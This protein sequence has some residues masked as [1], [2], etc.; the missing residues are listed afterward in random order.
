MEVDGSGVL[1]LFFFSVSSMFCSCHPDPFD[2]AEGTPPKTKKPGKW[3]ALEDHLRRHDF[4]MHAAEHPLQEPDFPE[5][6]PR[7]ATGLPW[8]FRVIDLLAHSV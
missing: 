3:E 1:T 2:L 7:R 5:T 6:P 4:I 8:A